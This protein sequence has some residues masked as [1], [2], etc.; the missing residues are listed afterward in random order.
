MEWVDAFVSFSRGN[1][2]ERVLESLWTRGVSSDQVELFQ[3]GYINKE[4]PDI[5]IPAG[6]LKQ[7]NQGENLE[8]SYVLPLTNT[9]G[10]ILGLQFRPV[11]R[12]IKKYSDYFLTESEPVLF[13]LGQS[14]PYIWDT[15][16][17]CIVEGGFDL[18]PVQRVI[19]FSFSTITS[20]VREDLLRW[21]TRLVRKLYLFYDADSSGIKASN[22]FLTE[23]GSRVELVRVLEYPRGVTLNGKP[24]KDPADLWEAWGDDKL[25][26]YLLE[27]ISE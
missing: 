22:D 16:S 17:A 26:P 6:F 19:P 25:G 27:Q 11:N 23:H 14:M 3:I 24:V 8:D 9:S 13:G 7:F 2:D 15:G 21:L 10:E 5:Q 1:L 4:L 20:K 12:S 18:F